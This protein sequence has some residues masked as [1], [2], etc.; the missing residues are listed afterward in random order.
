M[1]LKDREMKHFRRDLL[2]GMVVMSII[3]VGV[4]SFSAV[5]VE[6]S[7]SEVY[8]KQAVRRARDAFMTY[9]GKLEIALRV[10]KHYEE[11]GLLDVS[12][13]EQLR[14]LLEPLLKEH[15]YLCG[16]SVADTDGRSLYLTR[17][18]DRLLVTSSDVGSENKGQA[19]E[20]WQDG[21]LVEEHRD[22]KEFDPRS[23]KWFSAALATDTVTWTRPYTFFDQKNMGVTASI[24]FA[25][26][27]NG[28]YQVVA[29]DVLLEGLYEQIQKMAP[30]SHSL[31]R[32]FIRSESKLYRGSTGED[33]SSYESIKEIENLLLKEAYAAWSRNPAESSRAM[34][35]KHDGQPWWCGFKPL[36]DTQ[37]DVWVVVLVPS[38]DITASDRLRLW[39]LVLIGVILLAV[40][41]GPLFWLLR[42]YISASGGEAGFD[43]DNPE[44]SIRRLIK[45]GEGT[46]V[47]FKSTMRMNLHTKKPGKE[48]EIAWLKGVV[49]FMNTDGGTLLIGVTDDGE[50]TGLERDVFENEDKCRLHFKNLIAAHIGAEFSKYI[51]F[52]I[53]HI[54]DLTVGVAQCRRSEQPA[55]LKHPKG[56]GFYIRSG[57]SSDELPVSKV[58]DYI[59]SRK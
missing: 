41:I 14:Q 45:A 21:K 20:Y 42:R 58:M 5:K 22:S 47:E 25:L 34:L 43:A 1:I 13:Q 39:R 53:V 49:A 15:R 6:R 51:T 18:G 33:D 46:T 29:F 31:I 40:A 32:I 10:L 54:D 7:S 56:E 27:R 50:I 9:T 38:A 24:S 28:R 12:D 3:V 59:K 26:D 19:L 57:P 8:I 35:I 11:S 17:D 48:I 55:Y 44:G 23:R 16:I 36:S 4:L 37:Q 30:S 2:T 52:T